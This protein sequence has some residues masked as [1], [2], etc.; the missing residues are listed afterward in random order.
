MKRDQKNSKAKLKLK[1]ETVRMLTTGELSAAV[2]GASIMT[3]VKCPGWT[4]DCTH[5]KI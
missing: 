1:K 5:T 4:M 2:G 3:G